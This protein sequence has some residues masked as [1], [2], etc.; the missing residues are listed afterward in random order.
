M[1]KARLRYAIATDAAEYSAGSPDPVIF[2]FGSA[3]GAARPF[4]VRRGW[5]GPQGSYVEQFR[6]VEAGTRVTRYR[7]S[8]R[9]VELTGEYYTDDFEDRVTSLKLA[10]GEYELV[11]TVDND[12]VPA[13][14]V[15]V[16][17]GP[18]AVGGPPAVVPS[19]IDEATKKSD[20]VWLAVAGLPG[21]S[22]RPV[23]HLWHNGAAYLVYNGSEQ[24]V[25]GLDVADSAVV[26]VRSKDKGG[27]LVSWRAA[28][29]DVAPG[30]ALWEDVV[31]LLVGK[32]LNSKDGDGAAAR[33]A[34]E[35]KVA[36]LSPTGE[37][38][39]DPAAPSTSSQS[40]PPAPTEAATTTRIPINFNNS[41]RRGF[42]GRKFGS[43]SKD[44]KPED[45]KA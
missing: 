12:V 16:A 14:P 21:Q 37:L 25:P 7:S 45:S 39:D 18:G 43:R 1:P 17:P 15:F 19:I 10:T 4:L 42:S 33:W 26:T 27:R 34:R 8:K 11:F 3:G 41:V 44:V 6:I 36:R 31:P 22:H 29:D 9:V 23:W 13:V 32:R 38:V 5:T 24:L 20:L 2:V 30:T 40:A 35:C 28:V